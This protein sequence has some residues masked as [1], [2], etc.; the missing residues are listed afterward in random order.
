[1]SGQWVDNEWTMSGQWMDNQWTMS[2]QWV[3]NEWIMNG[4][5]VD[6]EWTMSKQ[7]VDNEWTLSGQR[8]DNEWT[9]R[10][11]R[12]GE[13]VVIEWVVIG[14]KEYTLS[15][16][17]LAFNFLVHSLIGLW[18]YR[19]RLDT[20]PLISLIYVLKLTGFLCFCKWYK[21]QRTL[22]R[23]PYLSLSTLPL[24]EK[25]DCEAK[26]TFFYCDRGDF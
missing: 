23:G 7:W 4:Q 15:T 10:E 25:L 24:R 17:I 22:T 16:L 1:M 3:N 21:T 5:W 8:V 9:M 12:F 13:W 11:C 20:S 18:A 14:C 26:L 19:E 2:G 6:N